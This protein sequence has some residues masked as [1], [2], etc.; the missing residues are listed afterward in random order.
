MLSCCGQSMVTD[1]SLSSDMV[2]FERSRPMQ[3]STLVFQEISPDSRSF[4]AQPTL[5]GEVPRNQRPTRLRSQ[6]Q[7]AWRCM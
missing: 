4:S 1:P 2:P 7:I 6:S 5:P 3:S